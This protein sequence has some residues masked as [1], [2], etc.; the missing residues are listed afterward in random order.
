MWPLFLVWTGLI[1]FIALF[2]IGQAQV[3]DWT[4]GGSTSGT[5]QFVS[6]SSFE[7]ALIGIV[8][9]ADPIW[10]SL[11][12]I[13]AYIFLAQAEGLATARRWAAIVL[14]TCAVLTW[15]NARTGSPFGPQAYTSLLG[16][17]FGRVLP[18][19]VPLL[20]FVILLGSRFAVLRIYP[21]ANLWLISASAALLTLTTDF[22][23]EPVAW[24]V[25]A[26]WIWYPLD[27]APPSQPP[28]QNYAGWFAAAFA[29][30]RALGENRKTVIRREVGIRPA[31]ILVLLNAVWLSVNIAR[32]MTS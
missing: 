19:A 30:T 15:I 7:N 23:L 1:F 18:F 28:W 13:N 2:N 27:F 8:S 14:G 24:K 31:L 20:W 3:L 26:Y 32:W 11:A 21:R 25:R 4:P 9:A 29:I 16:W 12:A 6:A 10:I 17:K 22:N 5:M